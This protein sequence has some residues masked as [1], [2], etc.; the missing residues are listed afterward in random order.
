M[1]NEGVTRVQPR[2]RERPGLLPPVVVAD[3][4]PRGVVSVVVGPP[5][6]QAELPLLRVVDPFPP[7]PDPVPV[8]TPRVDLGYRI[9]STTRSA[10]FITD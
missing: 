2:H 3:T 8:S 4:V 6:A 1:R 10:V 7:S 5:A 9:T